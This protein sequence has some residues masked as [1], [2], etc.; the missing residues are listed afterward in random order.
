M[1]PATLATLV[2]PLRNPHTFLTNVAT[3]YGNVA[4]IAGPNVVN[5]LN[6]AML[7][8]NA[9]LTFDLEKDL[10]DN[11]NSEVVSTQTA[12]DTGEPLSFSPRPR[13][14]SPTCASCRWC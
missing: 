1:T 2:S 14:P 9:M 12:H 11:F 8:V 4:A 5:E 7:K 13:L 3:N 10:L 6:D